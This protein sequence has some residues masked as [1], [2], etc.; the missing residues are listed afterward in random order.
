MLNGSKKRCSRQRGASLVEFCFTIP[1]LLL[2][3]GA[4]VDLSRYMRFLQITTFVSQ[5]TAE[6]IYRQC[7]D[8]TI[9]SPPDI[10]T[11]SLQI[12][13]AM[14]ESAVT[15]CVQRLQ[16]GAQELLNASVGRAAVSSKVFRWQITDTSPS[17]SCGNVETLS[18]ANVSVMYAK[19]D[20]DCDDAENERD[21]SDGDD[22]NEQRTTDSSDD[23]T[24][25]KKSS[26][27]RRDDNERNYDK[28]RSKLDEDEQEEKLALEDD[29]VELQPTG[30]YQTKSTSGTARLLV[31]PST[32]CQKSRVAT[33]EVAYAFE[34]IVKFLPHMMIKLNTDGSQRETTAL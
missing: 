5:E 16:L 21:D 24:K 20:V 8:I 6:Q 11:T 26:I 1:V 32:L 30:I 12:N 3:A 28:S 7:S 10:N 17:T 22:A 4:T 29:G 18:T 9:Y 34:P 25:S 13:K 15:S 23:N 19:A 14:T 33:V 31:S 27:I 2:V